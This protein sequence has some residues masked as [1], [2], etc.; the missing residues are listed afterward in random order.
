MSDER[1]P[2]SERVD[3]TSLVG[4]L[5]LAALGALLVLETENVIDLRLGFIWPALLAVAGAT[6]LASGLRKGKR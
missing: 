5:C 6:L 3:L 1:R 4:G 2:V